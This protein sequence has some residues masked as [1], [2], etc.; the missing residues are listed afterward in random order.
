MKTGFN[1]INWASCIYNLK[2]NLMLLLYVDDI[3]LFGKTKSHVDEA[4]KFHQKCFDVKVLGQTSKLL[5]VDFEFRD[6]QV[7]I[8]QTQ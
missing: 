2:N 4:V 7:F 5:G 1:K 6:S 8:N 3:V